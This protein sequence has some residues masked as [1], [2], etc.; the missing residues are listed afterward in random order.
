MKLYAKPVYK[1]HMTFL[2]SIMPVQFY[3]L[4]D[5]KIYLVYSRFFRV[6][7][8]KSGI[9]YIIA[10]HEEFF[11]D[12]Q[13]DQITTFDSLKRMVPVYS[14]T[15]NKPNPKI[16]IVNVFRSFRSVGEVYEHLNRKAEK[17]L[18]NQ[19]SLVP[20]KMEVGQPYL[21]KKSVSA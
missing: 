16:K 9:E 5:G 1:S 14:E 8:E 12:Y 2:P 10:E 7:Y 13:Q 4:P 17:I 6:G 3:G 19:N 21:S 20:V 11:Y 15:I 18:E